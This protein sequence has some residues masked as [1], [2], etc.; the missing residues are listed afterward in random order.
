MVKTFSIEMETGNPDSLR[1]LETRLLHHKRM[2]GDAEKY[3]AQVWYGYTYVWNKEQ[4]D[5]ELLDASG[6][7]QEFVIRDPSAA[8]GVRRQTWHFPSRTECALCHT[9]AAKYALGVNTAQM[10]RLHEYE[11]GESINQLTMLQELEMFTDELPAVPEELPHLADPAD[12]AESLDRRARSY[13]HAN[14]S[15]CHRLW[16]GGL[17]D[18]I[19]TYDFPLASTATLNA[20]PRRGSFELK[21]G[22][23]IVPG[24]AS[25]SVLH[26]RMTRLGIG[27]MPHVA[28]NRVDRSGVDVIR[29][30]IDAMP[31]E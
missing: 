7:D 16:G 18:M 6:L 27:R 2:Q 15:H 13:L 21:N 1:R 23:L 9:M 30:W 20:K 25:R 28:S 5:A 19:L 29:E 3:G 4:T 14:C 24:D 8:E 10:N 11:D 22:A 17:S 26:H 31:S 12:E